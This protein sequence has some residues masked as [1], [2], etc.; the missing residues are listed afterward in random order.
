MQKIKYTCDK[1]IN[2]GR[3]VTIILEMWCSYDSKI[4]SILW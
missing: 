4:K 1:S 3:I 2:L